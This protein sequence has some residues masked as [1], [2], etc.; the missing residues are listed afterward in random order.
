MRDIENDALEDLLRHASPRPSP[1]DDDIATARAAVREEW[2]EVTGR[3]HARRRLAHYAI[4][5]TVLLGIFAIFNLFRAPGVEAVQLASIE[6][7]FGSVYLLGEQSLLRESADLTDVLSGQTIITGG[8]AGLALAWGQGG[9]IRVDENTRVKFTD[10]QLIYLESGRIYFDSQGSS[11]V[12]GIDAGGGPALTV[13]T[14][15]GDI[16]HFGT[17]YMTEVGQETLIVTV[18]EGEVSFDGRF[19]DQT[20]A[21]GEQAKVTGQQRPTIL[22]VSRAGQMWDWI[23]RTT[24]VANVDGKSLHDFLTWV[25][26]EMGLELRFEGQAEAIARGAILGGKIDTAP[27]DA[28]R[29][30]L[31]TADLRSRIEGGVIYISD[32]R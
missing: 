31:V 14:D 25:C 1:S 10:E 15:F 30:R 21:S 29:F 17:Q 19:H 7:Q 3:R 32:I 16:Q 22:S 13:R 4:A 20:I 6:K 27:A 2:Q 26:R 8:D 11:L 5:A 9:S 18:R 24:P 12:A 23:Q 28:L